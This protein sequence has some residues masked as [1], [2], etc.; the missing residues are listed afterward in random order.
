M[1][2]DFV[3]IWNIS[4]FHKKYLATTTP[5]IRSAKCALH[6]F[7]VV[8]MPLI[9]CKYVEPMLI[10]TR[11]LKIRPLH[12]FASQETLFQCGKKIAMQRLLFF[13]FIN[14]TLITMLILAS[15]LPCDSRACVQQWWSSN[16]HHDFL[17][18]PRQREGDNPDALSEQAACS[19]HELH[20]AVISGENKQ[21]VHAERTDQGEVTVAEM[22]VWQDSLIHSSCNDIQL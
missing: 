1:V 13:Y 8:A 16:A 11:S 9:L 7:D 14:F 5:A 20:R 4:H 10:N 15:L 19:R 12:C 21:R 6:S 2:T 22:F 18:V 17:A 3:F